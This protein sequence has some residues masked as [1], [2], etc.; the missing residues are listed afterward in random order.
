[1]IPDALPTLVQLD[2]LGADLKIQADLRKVI[3]EISSN[4]TVALDHSADWE[5]SADFISTDP[6]QFVAELGEAYPIFSAVD[7]KLK[8]SFVSRNDGRYWQFTVTKTAFLHI[9]EGPEVIPAAN[10]ELTELS[11]H[12]LIAGHPGGDKRF[13]DKRFF[14]QIPEDKN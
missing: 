3:E 7:D 1:M 13:F 8:M 14:P 6:A 10:D 11:P 2:N 4:V 12:V 5:A 9:L